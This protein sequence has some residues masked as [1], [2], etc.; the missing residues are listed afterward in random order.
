[1]LVQ[2]LAIGNQEFIETLGERIT[3]LLNT[4]LRAVPGAGGQ[5]RSVGYRFA[6]VGIAG[7][8]AAE[9][10]ITE[11]AAG[12]ASQA[13][14]IC[15]RAWLG[16][17]GTSGAREDAQAVAQLRTFIVKHSSSRFETWFE[18]APN[19]AAQV[20]SESDSAPPERFRV[21]Q[22]A[23]WKRWTGREQG[24]RARWT[25]LMS[26]EG[27]HEALT[28]LG[29]RD[30]VK[31]LVELGHILPSRGAS[32]AKGN[33]VAGLHQVPGHGKVRLYEI[34]NGLLESIEGEA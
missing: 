34:S 33:V 17:R 5:V 14:E 3:A 13:A 7:E 10:R 30:A 12:W 27:L 23:G 32:D 1:M 15:F 19:P 21:Q 2:R 6:L 28:G 24:R 26:S 25:F 9:A 22:R 4:W 20:E 18:P 16:E 11:W 31:T 8:L 29:F